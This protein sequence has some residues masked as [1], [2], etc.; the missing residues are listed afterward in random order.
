MELVEAG[1]AEG[2]EDPLLL[3]VSGYRTVAKQQVLWERAVEKYGAES[4]ARQWVARPSGSA[5]HSG[6][7]IDLARRQERQ[8]ERRTPA[9]DS[10]VGLLVSN[11]ESFGFYPYEAEPWHWEYNPPQN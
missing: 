11:A 6:R 5:H 4:A 1:R 2:L 3:V 8:R 9:R 10:C 7:A